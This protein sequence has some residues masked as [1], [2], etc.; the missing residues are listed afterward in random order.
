MMFQRTVL[1]R[2]SNTVYSENHTKRINN[3]VCGRYLVLKVKA[4]YIHTI[5]SG[6]DEDKSQPNSLNVWT[7]STA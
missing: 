3:T 4:W 7:L 1:V 5:L 2:Q 6:S